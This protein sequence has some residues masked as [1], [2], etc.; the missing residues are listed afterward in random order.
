MKMGLRVPLKRPASFLLPRLPGHL[1]R[2]VILL[3]DI[4]RITLNQMRN[5]GLLAGVSH[6]NGPH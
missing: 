6:F 2:P 1:E 5:A 3:S 4:R